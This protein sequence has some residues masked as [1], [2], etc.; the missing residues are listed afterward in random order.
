MTEKELRSYFVNVARSYY[1]CN[2]SDG[3]HKKIIDIYNAHKPLARGYKVQYHDAWCA[4]YVSAMAIKCGLTEIIPTECSCTKMVELFK[5]AGRWEEADIYVPAPGDII[6]YDWDDSGKGD[7]TGS[8]DHVGIVV[9]ITDG[10]IRVIEG[11]IANAVGHRDMKINGKFIRG[12]CLPDFTSKADKEVTKSVEEVALEVIDG[13][14]GNNPERKQK[15]ISAGYD[16]EAVQK[17]VNEILSGKKSIKEIALE[18]IDGKWGNN[19]E[20]KKRLT[21]AGYDYEAVQK[22]VN[23]LL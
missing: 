18:V 5:K 19:P 11:N 9:R 12:Y 2:E 8:P 21:A 20:R 13:K 14:W 10:V 22:K 1:G 6:M 15:L 4:T 16:Y 23:E 3:S 7:N 17:K